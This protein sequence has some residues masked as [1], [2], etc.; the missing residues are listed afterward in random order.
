MYCRHN[1]TLVRC[2]VQYP[3]DNTVQG[4]IDNLL[5]LMNN[6]MELIIFSIT[7]VLSM[8]SFYLVCMVFTDIC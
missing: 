2:I 1:R 7:L 3:D 8:Y 6:Y 4:K 5:D